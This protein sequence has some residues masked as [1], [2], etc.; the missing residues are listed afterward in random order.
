[1]Q[2]YVFASNEIKLFEDFSQNI[3]VTQLIPYLDAH[4]HQSGMSSIWSQLSQFS[5]Y[6]LLVLTF[7]LHERKFYISQ[8]GYFNL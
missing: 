4:Y 3:A 2:E 1:M 8:N 5:P 6:A 7:Y